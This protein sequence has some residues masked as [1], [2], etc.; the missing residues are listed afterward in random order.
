VAHAG[1][2][3]Y[4]SSIPNLR[5]GIDVRDADK[6]AHGLFY[7]LLALFLAW[8]LARVLPQ[9]SRVRVLAVALLVPLAYGILDEF[10]QH[11]VPGRSMDP[12]DVLADGSGALL[13]VAFLWWRGRDR[14]RVPG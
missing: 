12:F 9:W 6:M 5:L 3:F 14:V 4:L 2:I 11:F 1:L 7:G 8:G 13:V 10:H